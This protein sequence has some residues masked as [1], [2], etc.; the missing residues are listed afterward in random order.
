MQTLYSM[1]V[2][3]G[4]LSQ[5]LFNLR[6]HGTLAPEQFA[7]A[8]KLVHGVYSD[9]ESLDSRLEK[10]VQGYNYDRV[11]TVDRNVLRIAAWELLNEPAIPPAVTIDEAIE[12]ARKFSMPESGKFVNG[13]LGKF[14][15]STPKADWDP[16]KAPA[17][18][19]EEPGE[20]EPM[21][22]IEETIDIESEEAKKLQRI[23]VW[24]LKSEDKS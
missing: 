3:K 7:Y 22:V 21:E 24:K 13:V 2:T 11:A 16:D 4:A 12:I 5:A 6:E 15:E 1:D 19:F 9:H 20:D 10:C 14:L 17:E 18:E 23:G 8:E